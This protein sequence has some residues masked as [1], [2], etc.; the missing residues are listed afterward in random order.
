[1]LNVFAAS[2]IFFQDFTIVVEQFIV[3]VVGG[4]CGTDCKVDRNVY[5]SEG[6]RVTSP[7]PVIEDQERRSA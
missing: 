5:S 6:E 3:H 7:S 1:M 2:L 4:E